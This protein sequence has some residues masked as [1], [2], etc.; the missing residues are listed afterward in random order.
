MVV[1]LR[2]NKYM[3]KTMSEKEQF[4]VNA[5][6]LSNFIVQDLL[7]IVGLGTYPLSEL[8]LMAASVHRLQPTHIIEWGTNIGKSARIFYETVKN[9]N[10]KSEI[11][12]IDLPSDVQHPE[13]S[14]EYRGQMVKDLSDVKLH[15]GDGLT[16]AIDIAEKAGNDARI[17]FFVDGDHL[18][19]SVY[20]EVS[21][22]L[23][24]FPT[25]NILVH[26]TFYQCSQSG[27]N[28]GPAQ[29]VN[30]ALANVPNDFRILKTDLGG[31]G[32]TLLYHLPQV[33]H[34][35]LGIEWI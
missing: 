3:D 10:I 7:P 2:P 35:L 12:S 1:Q 28:V 8:M 24:K 23:V 5:N 4:E 27:Y 19:N 31:P 32:M 11:H 25:Q 34:K 26:D 33:D 17:L 21:N 15:L 16:V 22:L 9:F 20:N 6:L 18:Y 29:A 13:N 14:L 30:D